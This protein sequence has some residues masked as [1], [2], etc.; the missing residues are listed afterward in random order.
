MMKINVQ[1]IVR[2]VRT[3]FLNPKLQAEPQFTNVNSNRVHINM[4]TFYLRHEEELN[5]RRLVQ[6]VGEIR[7]CQNTLVQ[8]F[9]RTGMK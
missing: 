1:C 6:S 9:Q 4:G 2:T 3:N 8:L 5:N 7:P